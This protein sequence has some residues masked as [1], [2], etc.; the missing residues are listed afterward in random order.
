MKARRSPAPAAPTGGATFELAASVAVQVDGFVLGAA[1]TA[2]GF[3]AATG[4]GALYGFAGDGAVRF[5]RPTAHD[6]ILAFAVSPDGAAAVTGGQ[7]GCARLWRLDGTEIARLPAKAAWV[8]HVAWRG[9]GAEIATAGGRVV[10]LWR[11]DGTPLLETPPLPSTVTGLAYLADGSLL[12]SCYGGVHRIWE[13]KLSHALPWAGSL[14]GV[15]PSPTN[16]VV[17]SPTQEQS[18]HFWRINAR[19]DG[20]F[21]SRSESNMQGYPFKPT[22]LAWDGHGNLL[23]SSGSSSVTIWDFRGAGPEGTRPISLEG[24]DRRGGAGVGHVGLVTALQFSP[25]KALLASGSEDG[26]VLLWEPLAKRD[27]ARSS[28]GPRPVRFAFL[29]GAVSVLAFATDGRL[30]AASST[31]EV[32]LF[33]I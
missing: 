4:E 11:P 18:I 9:D 3:L 19:S 2:D 13:G 22:V 29:D 20:K 25:R 5:S 28:E 33:S 17:A 21:G 24:I 26:S 27:A 7:D 14:L 8:E 23:A 10:R 12:A 15:V 32:R 30:L 16:T 1:F 6:G 31:G